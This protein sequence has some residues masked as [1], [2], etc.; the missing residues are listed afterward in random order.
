MGMRLNP[1]PGWPPMPEGF[2]PQPGWQ[3]DPSWPAPPPGWQLWIDDGQPAAGAY[4]SPGVQQAPGAYPAS[5]AYQAP[6]TPGAIP[7]YA[8]GGQYPAYPGPAPRVNRIPSRLAVRLISVGAVIVVAIV[9]AIVSNLNHAS[10][11]SATGQITQQ[12]SL[13]VFDLEVGDCFN[14][15]TDAMANGVDSVKAIPCTQSHDSQIFAK[16]DLA[17]GTY[18]GKAAVDDQAGKGCDARIGSLNKDVMT[19]SMDERFLVP[20]EDGWLHGDRTVSCLIVNSAATLKSSLL[21]G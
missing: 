14:N 3:P 21:N 2:V 10:R 15:P 17:A 12:G 19:D 6:G 11:S 7:P 9:I 13:S 16:F 4:S 18:P 5:N 20:E 1:P 8:P